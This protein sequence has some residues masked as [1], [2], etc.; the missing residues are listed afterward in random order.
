[1]V[2][3]LQSEYP[4]SKNIPNLKTCAF[5]STKMV[6]EYRSPLCFPCAAAAYATALSLFSQSDFEVVVIQVLAGTVIV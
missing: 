6:L 3:D 1:M 5:I 2:K 4:L